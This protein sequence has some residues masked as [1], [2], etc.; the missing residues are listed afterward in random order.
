MNYFKL[1]CT[2]LIKEIKIKIKNWC[3]F[4]FV[5]SSFLAF[6]VFYFFYFFVML[7]NFLRFVS[8]ILG[9]S[10]ANQILQQTILGNYISNIFGKKKKID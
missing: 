4:F 9:P 8:F 6:S 3:W 10:M 7:T 2:F 5:I 1:F